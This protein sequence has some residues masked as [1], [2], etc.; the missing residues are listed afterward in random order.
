MANNA[1]IQFRNAEQV[2]QGYQLREIPRF[3]IWQG[4]DAFIFKY[5]GDDMAVGADLLTQY[6]Q[7]LSEGTCIYTLRV[8]DN[9][10]KIN[11]KTPYDGSFNFRLTEYQGGSYPMAIAGRSDNVI[12]QKLA[13]MQAEINE[14]KNQAPEAETDHPL[15]MIGHI[16]EMDIVKEA[17]PV[18]LG[19]VIGGIMGDG[20][21][22][23]VVTRLAGV[24][25]AD[26]REYSDTVTADLDR[27]AKVASDVPGLIGKLAAL[28]EKKPNQFKMYLGMLNSMKL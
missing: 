25:G 15:G 8:Y 22:E 11:S 28:A 13:E 7:A 4:K 2:V 9:D 21:K 10:E 12:L 19:K 16:M 23:Q 18:L 26:W 24:P 20:E 3:A 27:I 14:L 5:D 6:L 1:A 17:L